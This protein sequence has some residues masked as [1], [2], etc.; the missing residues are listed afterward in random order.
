[1]GCQGG[2]VTSD[3]LDDADALRHRSWAEGHRRLWGQVGRLQRPDGLWQVGVGPGA[4]LVDGAAPAILAES[5]V[6]GVEPVRELSPCPVLGGGPVAGR[7][8][9]ALGDLDPVESVEGLTVTVHQYVVPL[10]VGLRIAR[11]HRL[12]LPVVIQPRRVVVGPVLGAVTSPESEASQ[13][14]PGMSA[15]CLHCLDLH[16]QD[17]DPSW[18]EVATSLGHPVHD[19]DPLP[20]SAPMTTAAEGLTLMLAATLESGRRC[21]PGLAYEFGIDAPHVVVRRWTMHPACPWHSQRLAQDPR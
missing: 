11:E 1:M 19:F 13:P 5:L 8:R 4:L 2:R 14:P 6:R 16:R 20:V 9:R 17:R 10:E 12:V 3:D 15:P 7:L 21:S 18:A